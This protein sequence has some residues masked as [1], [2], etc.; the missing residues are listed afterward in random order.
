MYIEH[1][2]SIMEKIAS[3]ELAAEWDNSGIQ[4]EAGKKEIKKVFVALEITNDV[5]NEAK[6][7][8]VDLIITHHPLIFSPLYKVDNN[9][10]IGNY[11]VKLIKSG[12]SVYSVHTNFDETDG[13]NNDYIASLLKLAKVKK[14]DGKTMGRIGELFVK[15]S[16]EDVCS[17]VK[18]S[19]KLDSMSVVGNPLAGIRRVGICC[20]AGAGMVDE[21]IDSGC[22]LFITGDIKYH[23]ARYALEKGICLIDAG[24]YGTEKFFVEN[25]AEKLRVFTRGMVEVIP[26]ELDID[27][28]KYF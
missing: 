20:G 13:G 18:D 11:V 6:E 24:H 28:F 22:D 26:S 27:P 16:F 8:K 10:I 5:I 9:T 23:D 3:P 15:M 7:Q 21:A 19:L 1:I 2:I 25:L 17:Y 12:I 14:F 4:I